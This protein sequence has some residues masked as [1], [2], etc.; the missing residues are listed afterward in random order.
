MFCNVCGN[1]IKETD[2]FC[3]KCRN[4]IKKEKKDG[5][6]IVPYHKPLFWMSIVSVLFTILAFHEIVMI[7]G[8]V[9][10]AITLI[11]IIIHFK[12][13]KS[14]KEKNNMNLYTLALSIVGVLG[15][16]AWLLFTYIILPLV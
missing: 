3:S 6:K 15:N 4:P 2:N 11:G 8:I 7:V 10:S 5:I 13:S 9:V 12:K 16:T 1:K 14:K